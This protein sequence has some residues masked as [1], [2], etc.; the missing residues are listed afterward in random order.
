MGLHPGRDPEQAVR[1]LLLAASDDLPPATDLLREVRRRTRRHRALVPSVAA[2]AALGVLAAAALTASTVTGTAPASAQELVAA[3]VTR[4]AR[5]GYRVR[6]TSSK[7][8]DPTVGIT[9][10][11]FD[12]TKRTAGWWPSRRTRGHVTI[13]IGDRVYVQIPADLVGSQPGIPKHARWLLR[14]T[15]YPKDA[16]IPR[17]ADFGGV[18]L[19]NPQQ[20]LDWVRSAGEVRKLGPAS[21][22]GWTG[23]RY[24]FTLT[25]PHSRVDG[26]VDVD[27]DGR[28][29]RLEFTSLATDRP[30]AVA[31]GVAATVHAVLEFSDFGVDEP[32]T[33]PPAD[34]EYELQFPSPEDLKDR[35]SRATRR[36]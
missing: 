8:P 19:Q 3:A 15:G 27:R 31:N 32:V 1:A 14:S 5:D 4:T 20:A 34:Q 33:A 25:D 12:P 2:V 21:G 18:A 24:A 22:Q 23:V 10:G 17:L 9:E 7:T 13:H 26:T 11:V 30:W 35:R 6:V 28:V 16:G 29:R 36:R